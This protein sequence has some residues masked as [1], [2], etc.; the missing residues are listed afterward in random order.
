MS[1]GGVTG[2][3]PKG[4]PG[5]GDGDVNNDRASSIGGPVFESIF[6]RIHSR[7]LHPMS[8]PP[9]VPTPLASP[10]VVGLRAHVRRGVR[11]AKLA[12]HPCTMIEM[13]ELQLEVS[14]LAVPSKVPT[15]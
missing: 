15:V 3:S 11:R 10:R 5:E 14:G 12:L 8:V 4:K 13:C 1:D 7:L 6:C 9:N 2:A